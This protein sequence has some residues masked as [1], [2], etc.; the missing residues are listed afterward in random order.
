MAAGRIVVPGWMPALDSNGAPIPNAQIYIY[1]NGTTTLATVYSDDTLTT[2]IANPVEANSSGRFPEIWADD[3]NLFSISVDAPFGPPGIPFSFDS[4]GPATVSAVIETATEAGTAAANAVVAGKANVNGDNTT[5]ASFRSNISAVF[6]NAPNTSNFLENLDGAPA[7]GVVNRL[8]DRVFM[9]GAV[10]NDASFPNLTKDWFSTFET[11]NGRANGL[12]VS[13]QS[14]VLTNDSPGSRVGLVVAARTSSVSSDTGYVQAMHFTTVQDRTSSLIPATAGYAEAWR[15]ND[16]CGSA[17]ALELDTINKGGYN[18]ITPY[19]QSPKQ[20]IA[21]QIAAGGEFSVFDSSAAINVRNNGAKFGAALIVGHN[22]IVGSDGATGTGHAIQLANRHQI[23]WYN[24]F[25]DNTAGI[26]GGVTSLSFK[27]RLAF[28]DSGAAF[29]GPTDNVL[30]RFDPV[31]NATNFFSFQAGTS[32]GAVTV[33][34]GGETNVDVRILPRGSGVV[35]LATAAVSEGRFTVRGP[36]RLGART[37]TADAPIVGYI[38]VE[39]DD[40]GTQKLAIIN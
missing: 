17:Q 5:P 9:G 4:I 24:A 35:S 7:G 21:L 39:S 2:P 18:A 23:S 29:L 22:A 36:L 32:G 37:N 14:A 27:T 1:L 16:A 40:G 6:K 12:I 15:M 28:I 10:V 25:G 26:L 3:A 11:A 33:G 34:A 30:A 8:G 19:A 20:D 38:T 13:A 31:A